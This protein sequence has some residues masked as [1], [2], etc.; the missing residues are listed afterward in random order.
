MLKYFSS[1]AG[2]HE[3]YFQ[4]PAQICIEYNFELMPLK[5]ISF[6]NRPVKPL[7]LLPATHQYPN[8][9]N[10]NHRSDERIGCSIHPLLSHTPIP[11]EPY[12][13]PPRQLVNHT[14]VQYSL[15]ISIR[16]KLLSFRL[17]S[18]FFFRTVS[19]QK[20]IRPQEKLPREKINRI[21]GEIRLRTKNICCELFYYVSYKLI[22]FCYCYK[23]FFYYH[24][25]FFRDFISFFHIK[26][27]C[28]GD[29]IF[30]K[31]TNVKYN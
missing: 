12:I 31:I 22:F 8:G 28:S 10:F 30:L 25:Q 20:L 14:F 4:I 1:S 23:I 6:N 13:K 9:Y 26:F 2:D 7:Q 15:L 27:S 11:I 17:V 19:F 29:V 3:R 21:C 5:C 16:D 24:A 18:I